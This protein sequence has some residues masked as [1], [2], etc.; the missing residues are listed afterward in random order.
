MKGRRGRIIAFLLIAVIVGAVLRSITAAAGEIKELDEAALYKTEMAKEEN[1][2]E[3]ARGDDILVNTEELVDDSFASNEDGANE[4]YT[5]DASEATYFSLGED[6]SEAKSEYMDNTP[7]DTTG[8][9]N[10]CMEVLKL[11]TNIQV[12]KLI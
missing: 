11:I 3:Y 4:D 2:K 5:Q 1:E 9:D 6:K 10:N 8:S 12:R 7:G